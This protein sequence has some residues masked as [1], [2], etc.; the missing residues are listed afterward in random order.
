MILFVS[1][2]GPK[3][4]PPTSFNSII[5]SPEPDR[6]IYVCDN[7]FCISSHWKHFHEAIKESHSLP[8]K[9]I[10]AFTVVQSHQVKFLQARG[11]PGVGEM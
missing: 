11:W 5:T 6:D 10:W 9:A 4:V 8:Q 2:A 3:S 1:Q 7:L